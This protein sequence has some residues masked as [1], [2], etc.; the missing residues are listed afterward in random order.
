MRLLRRVWPYFLLA[1]L[2]S[3]NI[4]AWSQRQNIADW[5]RLR[6]YQAPADIAALADDS[7]MTD[8]ARKLFYINHPSLED[9]DSFNS[10]CTDKTEETA[11]LGCYHGDR[12][13]IYIYAVTDERLQGVREVTAA[14]EMLHQAYDRLGDSERT[15]INGLLEE[16]AKGLT[17][18]TIKEKLDTYKQL[19]SAV[20]PNE[21]HSIFGTE[22]RTL[23]QELETYY[24][25]YFADRLK[26]VEK[27]EAYQGEFTRR[28]ELVKQYDAN[29][30]SLKT[31]INAN[32]ATLEGEMAFLNDKEKEINQDIKNG[33]QAAYESDVR[34]YNETVNA[35]NSLL[36]VTRKLISEHNDIVKKRNDIAVQEQQ[37]Q[38]ALDSRLDPPPTKQ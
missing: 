16:Y 29:L 4:I 23:P 13:G 36:A 35:Y 10:H 5:W 37:L 2:L 28:Q 19:E 9:K 25:K 34:E 17:D 24:K 22:V 12:Q 11:V 38:Q 21:M 33:D 27:R 14:H 1:I 20:L 15:Y 18:S 6:N 3:A 31:R 7:T 8:Y 32:K 30:A 26:V